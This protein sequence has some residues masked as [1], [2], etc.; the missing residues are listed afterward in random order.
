LFYEV[1]EW[2]VQV[3]LFALLILAGDT[4]YRLGSHVAENTGLKAKSQ[5]SVVEASLVGVLG[6]LL[7]FTMSMVV[8]RFE[9]R[10]QLVLQESNAISTALL[11]TQ[12]LP[13][14]ERTEIATLLRQ[15]IGLRLQFVQAGKDPDRLQAVRRTTIGLQNQFWTK[16]S[17][18]GHDHPDPV[19]IGLL[20]QS[21]NEVIDLEA[22]RWM[23]FFNH[24]PAAVI[25]LDAIVA[26]LSATLVGYSFGIERVR[27]VFSMCLLGLA[28]TFALGVIVDL[29]RPR[30]G[31]IQVS[32]QP[33]IDLQRSLEQQAQSQLP[34]SGSSTTPSAMR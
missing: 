26:L 17:T 2:V 13:E 31:L 30:H 23:S 1:N 28:I 34:E 6:L 16:A 8:T 11:R 7:G 5:I 29:D 15:Y 14:P 21:L 32:Q 20:L 18:Y 19:R 10:K 24:V 33:M 27:H 3:L 9:V 22:A 4:G 25:C 12:L